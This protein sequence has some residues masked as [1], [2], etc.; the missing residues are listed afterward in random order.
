MIS[1]MIWLLL[2]ALAGAL[3]VSGGS[4]QD[5][6]TRLDPEARAQCLARGGRIMI[7]GLLGNE[8]CALPL[9]DAGKRCTSGDQCIGDCLFDERRAP[10]A[11][12]YAARVT[13]TCQATNYGFG[14]RTRVEKGRI[15]PT[16][17][18]D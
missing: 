14:C 12:E 16:L 18:V 5:R 8:M 15:Q 1:R 13:G 10:T 4:A 3:L 17:C 7:A 6:R 2:G 11:R 9:A